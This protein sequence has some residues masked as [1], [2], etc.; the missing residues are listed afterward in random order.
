MV[1]LCATAAPLDAASPGQNEG[2]TEPYR[3]VH[4]AAAE[5]GVIERLAV[6]EGSRVEVGE[7]VAELD[8]SVLAASLEV[9]R[10]IK[11]SRAALA[12]AEAEL[13]LAE[14]RFA[15][16]ERLAQASHATPEEL[17]RV[18]LERELAHGRVK[19]AEESRAVK[20]A[21][22]RKIEA[23][24]DR[25]RVRS[26]IDG[27]VIELHKQV[28]EFVAPTDPQVMTV[29]QLDALRATFS[30][31]LATSRQYA[32]D[33]AVRVQ[34]AANP[35]PAEAV[36]EFVSPVTDARSGTVTVK[37]RIDN[38][39]GRYRSGERCLLL[40]VTPEPERLTRR[41]PR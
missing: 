26:P 32:V 41:L 24:L 15:Q 9:A 16:Y 30:V 11:D 28:G 36:V 14:T 31:P 21:E 1:L 2:F 3:L 33:Q 4:L 23:Q 35:G 17:E 37:V 22:F 6:R 39:A 18:R 25:R 38:A 10:V 8:Q 5:A 34:I 27:V 20:A 7:V 12:A 40:P 13:R 19:A 29:A